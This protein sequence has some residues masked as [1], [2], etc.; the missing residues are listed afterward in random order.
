MHFHHLV[1]SNF[2]KI[3]FSVQTAKEDGAIYR[4]GVIAEITVQ[5]WKFRDQKCFSRPTLIDDDK[6]ETLI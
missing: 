5:K 3:K 1:L 2:Q 6:I 4:D